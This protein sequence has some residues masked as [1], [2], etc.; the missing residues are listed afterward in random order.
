MKEII[1]FGKCLQ[2]NDA[3]TVNDNKVALEK[4]YII[5][6]DCS[7]SRAVK[8]LETLPNNL[9]TTFYQEWADVTEMSRL[10]LLSDQVKHYA[11]TYGTDFE[12]E[13]YVPNAHP[14]QDSFKELKVLMPISFEELTEKVG[15]MLYSGIALKEE[16]LNLLFELIDELYIPIHINEIKNKEAMCRYC[17]IRKLT[18][19]DPVEMMRYLVYNYTGWTTLIKSPEAINLIKSRPSTLL[20]DLLR[21]MSLQYKTNAEKVMAS[22]FF[23]FKP[24]FLA[25]KKGNEK[26]VNKLRRL[27]NKH[28]KPMVAGK[29]ETILSSSDIS[30]VTAEEIDKI[31][32]FKKLRLLNEISVRRTNTGVRPFIIRNGKVFIKEGSSNVPKGELFT[33]LLKS[34]VKSLK[35]KACRVK[36]PSRINLTAPTS[37]KSFVGHIPYGSSVKMGSNC[38]VGIH[39]TEDGGARDLDLSIQKM[40]GVKVGWNGSYNNDGV[41]YSGDMTC[42]NPEATEMLWCGDGMIDGI[43]CVNAYNAKDNSKYHMFLA[44]DAN[45]PKKNQMVHNDCIDFMTPLEVT[46]EQTIGM[47]VKNRFIFMDLNSSDSRVSRTSDHMLNFLRHMRQI[48]DTFIDLEELLVLAGFEFVDKNP[49]LDLSVADKS[50][51]IDL[52]R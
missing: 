16:T 21:V 7:A 15:S 35:D 4:G 45:I 25:M 28:H 19:Q 17:A 43:V 9:N 48:S 3:I 8:F 38:I 6:P 47:F 13:A 49:D 33:M 1:L 44:T 31:S 46:G 36:L 14:V 24:L 11:S 52:F 18:P 32:N 51:L 30:W 12:G 20:T 40:D 2:G 10:E 42:A 27:A 26:T 23:R 50:V 41:V 22:V 39:W 37:E 29:W 34:L 5:H